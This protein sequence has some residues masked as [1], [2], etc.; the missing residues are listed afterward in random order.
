MNCANFDRLAAR[1]LYRE[2][3]QILSVLRS[4]RLLNSEQPVT[5]NPDTLALRLTQIRQTRMLRLVPGA[6]GASHGR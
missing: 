3:R 2:E 1:E 6:A 4:G 5:I